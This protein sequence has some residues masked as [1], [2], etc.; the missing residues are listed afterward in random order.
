MPST[1]TAN[2]L[3]Q[4]VAY[5]EQAETWGYSENQNWDRVDNLISGRLELDITGIGPTITLTDTPGLPDQA[6]NMSY[7]F[8]GTLSQN[9]TVVL[10]ARARAVFYAV[11]ATAPSAFSITLKSSGSSDPL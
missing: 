6:S 4:K 3:L 8:R 10:P 2:T 11:D 9:L 5:D 7:I 1:Y